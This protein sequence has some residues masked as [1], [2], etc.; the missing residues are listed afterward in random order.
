MDLFGKI[1]HMKILLVD[2]DKW[3][4]D[5]MIFLFEVEGCELLAVETAEEGI[6]AIKQQEF[7]IAIVDYR[8]PGMDGLEFLRYI[9]RVQPETLRILITAYNDKQLF[10]EADQMGIEDFIAKPFTSEII[11]ASLNRLVDK[12]S[13]NRTDQK[14]K[15]R[16]KNVYSNS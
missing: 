8:L 4:R 11:E 5:S 15:R 7:D 6:K 10:T 16:G 9:H 3:I 1:K 14:S 13:R 2:D 12:F